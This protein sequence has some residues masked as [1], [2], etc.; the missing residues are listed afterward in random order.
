MNPHTNVDTN[1]LVADPLPLDKMATG[2]SIVLSTW[3]ASETL[4]WGR[5][6][7]LSSGT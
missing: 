4:G 1:S 5:T 7:L 6:L 2:G 3:K